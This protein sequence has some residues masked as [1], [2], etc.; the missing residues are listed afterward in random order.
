MRTLTTTLTIPAP[1][2]AV[3]DVLTDIDRYEEWNPFVLRGSGPVE[4]GGRLELVIQP[5]G[6]RAMTFRP[7]VTHLEPSRR[8]A[9]L[10]RLWGLPGLFEGA[11]RFELT[12]TGSGTSLVHAED[13]RGLLVPALWSSLERGSLAGFEAMNEALVRRVADVSGSR[14]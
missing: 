13:F 6:G 2:D 3:W 10:G 8:F 1:P 14:A 4:V 9:W 11:H 7:R 12:A 5:V